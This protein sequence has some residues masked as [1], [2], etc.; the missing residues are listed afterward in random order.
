MSSEKLQERRLHA[1]EIVRQQK[2]LVEQRQR[3]LLLK[4]IRDQEND[5]KTLNAMKQKYPSIFFFSFLFL[6]INFYFFN[7]LLSDRREQYRRNI[8]IRK[9]L[10]TNWTQA[11][12]EKHQ[13][14][15][16]EKIYLKAPQGILIHEQCDQYKRC[17]Q[18][19]RNLDNTGKTNLWK[20]TRYIPGTHIMV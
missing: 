11:I 7:S 10:E 16:D 13:R 9:D 3:Q 5:L 1:M 17:A 12:N 6:S 2:D 15:E 20:D 4:Q 19:Q 14:D 8:T 18:C